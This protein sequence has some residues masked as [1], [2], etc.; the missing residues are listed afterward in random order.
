M[1]CDN[2]SERTGSISYSFWAFLSL[3]LEVEV[4]VAE[5]QNIVYL[6]VYLCF[7]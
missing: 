7:I 6:F 4:I 1:V 5:V 2:V 3:A